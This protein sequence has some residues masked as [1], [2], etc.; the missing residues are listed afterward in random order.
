MVMLSLIKR[1]DKWLDT[2]I[3]ILILLAIV[4]LL[5]IPNLFE[6]NWYGD[7]AIY[8]TIG[9]ALKNGGKLYQN[10]IDHKTPIIYYLAMVSNH[11]IFR[12]LNIF[13]ML[14]AT[15]AF[16]HMAKKIIKPYLLV[17]LSS[18]FFILATTLPLLEGNIP[19]G[20]LFVM[21]FILAGGYLLTET[22][23][24]KA[25]FAAKISTDDGKIKLTKKDLGLLFTAGVLFGLGILTKVP[26][27]FD[28]LAFF[29]PAWFLLTNNFS[30][31]SL[32]LKTW[33]K[34]APKIILHN[35]VLA[36]GIIFSIVASI[37]YFFWRG[38]IHEYLQFGL[39]YN[40]RYASAWGLPFSNQ[41]LTFFFTLPGKMVIM[42]LIVILLML[43]KKA[44][45]IKFQFVATWTLFAIFGSLLSNRPY[46]HY[47]LQVMPPLALL[48]GLTLADIYSL[49]TKSKKISQVKK[50][51][52]VAISTLIIALFVTSL[53]LLKVGGYPT[54]SYYQ[55][56]LL[57]I[58]GKMTTQEYRQQFNV[59]TSDN[60]KASAIINRSGAKQIFIWGTNPML[61]S[62]SNTYPTGRFTV[63]FHIKDFKAYQETFADIQK[64]QPIFI[65]TMK[66]E[67]T[68]LPGLNEYLDKYYAPNHNFT[69]FTLWERFTTTKADN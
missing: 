17:L 45:S 2:H 32:K 37:G 47:F 5:R 59:L 13:W 7:E 53:M 18:V 66:D 41:I 34:F 20:E 68:E 36:L 24:F 4:I 27:L 33:L 16:H 63:S 8:L 35:L 54:I 50:L 30:F 38:S 15:V 56:F 69:Y 23:L 1:F 64:Q 60:Y 58:S 31:N 49:L 57:M 61:Y 42:G 11:R 9:N 43:L 55:N 67:Q 10:I 51:T 25:I 39:L 28:A 48:I 19:N 26:G 12:L 21:G 3:L 29:T 6:P 40:F 14:V 65:I 62:L 44:L 46:P 22:N 52:P